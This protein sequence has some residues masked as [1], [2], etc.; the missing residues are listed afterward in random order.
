MACNC[1]IVSTIVGDVEWVMGNIK[2]CYLAKQDAEN[3][4]EQLELALKFAN[5]RVHTHG[6]QRL[7]KLG[8]DSDTVSR[9]LIKIYN[10][11]IDNR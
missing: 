4:S 3:I 2:G 6:R 8:L 11:I 9:K 5:K 10:E 7:I 1:P